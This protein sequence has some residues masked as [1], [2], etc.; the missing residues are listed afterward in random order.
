MKTTEKTNFTDDVFQ[1][2]LPGET[3]LYTYDI[4][5]DHMGGLFWYHPHHHGST[6]LQV[7]P[8][9]E[10]ME[11]MLMFML[12]LDMSAQ[13]EL[14]QLFN[15][16]SLWQV[17]GTPAT[18]WLVNGQSAP[19]VTV[20][21]N[22]WYRWRMVF[23][24]LGTAA[25]LT[26]SDPSCEMR[27]LAKDGVFLMDAGRPVT[28]IRL[29]PGAR[30]DVAVRCSTV[31]SYTMGAATET[32]GTVRRRR[33][34]D[35]GDHKEE[36]EEEVGG[37]SLK[38][39]EL[40]TKNEH[41]EN[42]TP[43]RSS[44]RKMP[45]PPPPGGGPTGPTDDGGGGVDFTVLTVSVAAASTAPTAEDLPM[46]TVHRPCYLANTVG[47]SPT[48]SAN[49]A[50]SGGF[51]LNNA[52]FMEG[53]ALSGTFDTGNLGSISLTGTNNHPFH[54]H[55][56]H[57][58]I[59]TLTGAADTTWFQVGDW[60]DVMYG[61][62]GATVQFYLDRFAGHM[63]AHCHLLVHEDRGMM[64]YFDVGGTEGAVFTAA[65]SSDSTCYYLANSGDSTLTRSRGGT[66]SSGSNSGLSW[67]TAPNP[68]PVPTAQPS[69]APSSSPAPTPV[70]T[71]T[72][73]EVPPT[74]TVAVS[75]GFAS[76]V[77]EP[78]AG[79]TSEL[80]AVVASETGLA[81]ELFTSFTVASTW[82]ASRLRRQLSR[83]DDGG[84][85]T[86][87]Q[88][89]SSPAVSTGTV[90]NAAPAVA[91]S[92]D[93]LF[94]PRLQRALASYTWTVSFTIVATTAQ[95]AGAS[96]A[97][98]LATTVEAA[99]TAPSF[100]AGVAA[101]VSGGAGL[102]LDVGSV[103]A[104]QVTPTPAPSAAPAA[105]SPTTT[106]TT[107]KTTSPN[108]N[109]DDDKSSGGGGAL[110]ATAY[111][112]IIGAAVLAA[113]ALLGCKLIVDEPDVI[114]FSTVP[115]PVAVTASPVASA[116]DPATAAL[117]ALEAAADSEDEE[118][119]GDRWG[120]SPC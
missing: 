1:T 82:A 37:G 81:A 104:S 74:L 26:F 73:T 11:E 14:Q 47:S 23:G 108:T 33:R 83:S 30:A 60:H 17:T 116:T 42:A 106:T 67:S 21:P 51:T 48:Q 111:A 75:L 61:M 18:V 66:Y 54:M 10:A 24:A 44:G 29:F 89:P 38:E 32:L 43:K 76:L 25:E 55:V 100:S 112:I 94:P 57:Y 120:A 90:A 7:P 5:L 31:G 105:V 119:G 9:V 69:P 53:V 96:T 86:L 115:V 39:E 45:P 12:H 34:L 62:T 65:Q 109:D 99:L 117:A 80:K 49:L 103:S 72:P 95:A 2:V 79:Q 88:S 19:T 50:L 63:V 41:D 102:T 97:T 92:G 20:E 16:D 27:L 85:G 71:T 3:K 59:T 84:V 64:G 70:P 110:S 114:D 46:F 118:E 36:E 35:G 58:Q 87:K 101:G 13:Q 40:A 68:T 52:K 6:A 113:V 78:T 98:A 56:N 93:S 4:P 77:A 22:T 107:T 15:S 28:S 91:Q 8:E